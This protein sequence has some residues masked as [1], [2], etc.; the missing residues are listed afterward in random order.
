MGEGPH[1]AG[2]SSPLARGL[3]PHGRVRVHPPRIIPAR[4]GFT[5]RKEICLS[6]VTDH[7]RSRGVYTGR[8]EWRMISAGSSPLARGLLLQVPRGRGDIGII[9]ARA[10]FTRRRT[11]R[12]RSRRD[13]PRSRGVYSGRPARTHWPSGSSPLARGLLMSIIP[14]STTPR[15]IPARAGFTVRLIGDR[16]G[17]GDH[18]RSRGVYHHDLVHLFLLGGSSPLA[19]GLPAGGR[20]RRLPPRIIPARAGFTC[21]RTCP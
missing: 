19:R 15:I 16:R 14:G 17:A 11:T 3:P 5:D 20:P 8:V 18:P 10:G 6:R 4:A 12:S 1:A 13:H 21:A 7:P 2:G 9:P